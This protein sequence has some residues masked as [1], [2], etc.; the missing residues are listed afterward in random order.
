MEERLQK[1][2]AQAGLASRRAAEA[3]ILAG[4]VT[5]DGQTVSTLGCKFDPAK[6]RICVDGREIAAEKPVYLLL[7]KPRGY[8]TTL[9]DPQGRRLVTELVRE[10]PE[11]VFPVGRLDYDTEGALILT[12]DG[13]F[14][15]SILHPSKA[16]PRTYE[17]LV[18]GQ[19]NRENL[20]LLARGVELDDGW[21]TSPAKVRVLRL[22][23]GRCLMELV[24]HEG[25]K[26]QVRRMCQAVGHRVLRLK[27]T[28]YGGLRLGDLPSGCWTALG[29]EELRLIFL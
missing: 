29:P 18:S 16:I 4:R 23:P 14:A 24:I 28:A 27:R 26:R 19:P 3:M 8:I 13:A 6:V 7:N 15:H 11:R 2:L 25:K 22:M 9:A 12:N 17:A 1:I 20:R 21:R 10:I 5:V